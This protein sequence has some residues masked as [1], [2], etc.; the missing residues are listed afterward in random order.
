MK[1]DIYGVLRIK[2]ANQVRVKVKVFL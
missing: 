2:T 1:N